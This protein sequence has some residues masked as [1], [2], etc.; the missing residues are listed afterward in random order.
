MPRL[1]NK[2]KLLLSLAALSLLMAGCSQDPIFDYIS[3]ET[4]PTEARIQGEPSR[5][6]DA[7][8]NG[9]DKLYITNGRVWEYDTTDPNARWNRMAKQPRGSV[10]DLASAGGVLYAR[11]NNNDTGAPSVWKSDGAGGWDAT[12]LGPHQDYPLIVNIFGADDTL[13]ATGAKRAD[14][15]SDFALL[16][17]DQSSGEFVF[18]GAIGG[19][20][21]SGAGKIGNDYFLATRGNGIYKASGPVTPGT[22]IAAASS[23][24]PIP[25]KMAGLLQAQDT[26]SRDIIIGVSEAGHIVYIDPSGSIKADQ[27]TLGGTYTGALTLIESPDP[28]GGYDDLLLLGY[29]GSTSFQHGYVELQFN[30]DSGTHDGNR[31]VPGEAQPSSVSGGAQQYNASLRRYPVTAL[32]APSTGKPPLLIFAS[33]SNQGLYSYRNRSDGGW[34]WNHEE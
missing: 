22:T 12:P 8:D 13:F 20:R 14:N 21:L 11:T 2:L 23:S 15:I 5:I 17:Y 9:V 3:G 32:W 1:R 25:P 19:A 34:Q 26:Q 6:V 33:T 7:T 24:D 4:A 18:L 16:Y 30:S 29:K 31:R 28:Q 10:K 27:T